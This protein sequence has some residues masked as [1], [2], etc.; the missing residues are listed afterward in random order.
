MN[1]FKYVHTVERSRLFLEYFDC[2]NNWLIREK[3][4]FRMKNGELRKLLCEN[5]E[6]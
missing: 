1:G 2:F 3:R 6:T 5:V 4:I